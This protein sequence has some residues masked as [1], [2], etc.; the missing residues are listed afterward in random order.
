[1]YSGEV[2][3]VDRVCCGQKVVDGSRW[4]HVQQYKTVIMIR[5]HV[6]ARKPAALHEQFVQF[7]LGVYSRR[8]GPHP[9]MFSTLCTE[10]MDVMG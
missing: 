1:M 10:C 8:C 5:P 9:S 6:W 7:E 4:W 2:I 3:S